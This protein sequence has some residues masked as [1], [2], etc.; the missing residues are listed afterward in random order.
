MVGGA[1]LALFDVD[2]SGNLVFMSG[3]SAESASSDGDDIY[4]VQVQATDKAGNTSVVQTL[5]VTVS[6][7]DE[8]DV[9]AVTDTDAAADAV[10]ESAAADTLVGIDASA[11]DGDA[12]ITRSATRWS[13]GPATWS[14]MARSRLTRPRVWFRCGTAC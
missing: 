11:T 4:D 14:P 10:Q 2:A 12:T 3:V 5:A 7:V 9:G 6:D 8:F 1:D 13:T